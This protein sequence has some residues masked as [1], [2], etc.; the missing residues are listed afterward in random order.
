MAVS[1]TG[2]T[3]LA[4][5]DGLTLIANYVWDTSTLAW[6]KST[7]GSA[8]GATVTVDNFPATYAVTGPLTDAQLRA[9]A[10]DTQSKPYAQ[11]IDEASAT[12]TYVAVAAI[13]TV[14][15]GATWQIKRL[16]T[17]G[18]VVTIEWADGNSNFDN[19]WNDRASL[20]Y[21]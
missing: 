4:S 9:T 13:G 17:S 6:I 15:A 10:V 20:A 21:S 12:V 2:V 8:G 5:Q 14:D 7:G 16:T 19:V 18:N 1:L 3:G 11:R